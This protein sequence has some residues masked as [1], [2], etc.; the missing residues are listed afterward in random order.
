MKNEVK[1]IFHIDLNAFYCSCAIIKEPYLKGKVFVIGGSGVTRRG[2]IST[3]SYKARRYGIGSAMTLTDAFDRYPKLVV[4]PSDFKLYRKYSKLFFDY[5]RTYADLVLPASIDEAYIDMTEQSKTKHPLEIAKEIQ[6]GLMDLYQLPCSIG[7]AP[8]LFLAKMA[9]DMKKPLGVTVIRKKD[10]VKKLFP[11]PIKEMHGI[12][13]KTYPKLEQIGIKTIG[14]F[15]KKQYQEDI[16]NIMSSSSYQ[17]YISLIMGRSNDIVDP[18]KYSVHQSISNETTLNYV[19]DQSDIVLKVID[20]LID[21]TYQRLIKEE[22][23]VKTVGIKFKYQDFKTT[24]RSFSFNDYHDD[25]SLIIEQIHELVETYYHQE[26]VRLIGV[27]FQQIML[28]KDVKVDI[29]LFN[30][31]QFTHRD[32]QLFNKK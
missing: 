16:L 28:K 20:D 17:G 26:P 30:Y 25:K 31:Q 21:V 5:L 2:V 12:G 24:T 27:S 9:S 29:N 3:A 32:K 22:Y 6:E 4:V 14:D 13:K 11:L 23:V 19:I 18:K 15:T 8:T 7:I 10:I 1:I